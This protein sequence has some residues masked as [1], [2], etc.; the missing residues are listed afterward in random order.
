MY[1]SVD[2]QI[3]RRI[4]T[5]IDKNVCLLHAVHSRKPMFIRGTGTKDT[6]EIR[7]AFIVNFHY[8]FLTGNGFF[9]IFKIL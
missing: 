7:V 4:Q 2:G 8:H 9:A 6:A 3:Q 5:E 1:W